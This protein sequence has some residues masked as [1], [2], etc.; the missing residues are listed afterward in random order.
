M[1][2][3]KDL[4]P[5]IRKIIERYFPTRGWPEVDNSSEAQHF[6]SSFKPTKGEDKRD[7]R[8]VRKKEK[9]QRFI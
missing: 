6:P 4:L 1:E 3:L 5:R 2:I 9:E 7:V 8:W